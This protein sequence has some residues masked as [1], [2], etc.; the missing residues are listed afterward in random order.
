V[1]APNVAPHFVTGL[2]SVL[3]DVVGCAGLVWA[4]IEDTKRRQ[5]LAQHA[6]DTNQQVAFVEGLPMRDAPVFG[7]MSWDGDH[8]E[9]CCDE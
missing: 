7:S 4:W 1:N 3:F 6:L 2:V 9:F 8:R 5:S